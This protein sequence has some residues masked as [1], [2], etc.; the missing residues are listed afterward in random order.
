MSSLEQWEKLLKQ[1]QIKHKG[2]N[3]SHILRSHTITCWGVDH[4]PKQLRNTAILLKRIADG[5]TIIEL[6]EFHFVKLR[7]VKSCQ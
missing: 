2:K 3:G 4:R 5:R 6:C 1:Q 7:G